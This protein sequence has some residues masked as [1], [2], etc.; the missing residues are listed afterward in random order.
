MFYPVNLVVINI[1]GSRYWYKW[2][3]ITRFWI[4]PVVPFRSHADN[5][6]RDILH[7]IVNFEVVVIPRQ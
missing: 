5:S 7:V 1:V 2:L 6:F 4:A 3:D